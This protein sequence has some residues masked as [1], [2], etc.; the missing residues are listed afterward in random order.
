MKKNQIEG[1]KINNGI[2]SINCIFE[3]NHANIWLATQNAGLLRYNSLH[4]N[5]DRVIDN[6]E[7]SQ[8]IKYNYNVYCIF[9]DKE[10]NIWLGT[11]RGIN[12]FNPY[13]NYIQSVQHENHN[14]SLPKNE[15]L[16]L[17]QTNTGDILVGTWG[18][19]ISVYDSA[20][21]FRKNIS[22]KGAYENNLVWCF[23]QKEDGK[24]WAGCQHGYLHTYDPV[25]G[26]VTTIHPA[27]FQG[28]T[29]WCMQK[30]N[31]GNIWF[32]LNNGKIAK[33]DK[34]SN[35]FL[36]YNDSLKGI[37]QVFHAVHNIFI[38][39]SNNIWVSTDYGLKQ[40]DPLKR[41][42]TAVYLS[43]EKNSCFGFF[44]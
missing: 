22:I 7:T 21:Q 3:D 40:F 42:Y 41:I 33:W 39:R 4:D 30:D 25:T 8:G 12:I 19:G 20:L 26:E 16:G 34:S 6:K 17:I 14:T 18:G 5:F 35:K 36:P 13:Q 29:I 2:L 10:N 37:P 27:E 23:I 38:D 15:I 28:S 44:Q 43:D 24:I 31:E 9:Q 32:G 11:D 1:N